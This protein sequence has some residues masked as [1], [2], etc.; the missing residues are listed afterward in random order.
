MR[1]IDKGW[2]LTDFRKY[3]TDKGKE[4]IIIMEVSQ[5]KKTL[6]FAAVV[7]AVI[8]AI[9][10]GYMQSS[11]GKLMRAKMSAS[12]GDYEKAL[13]HLSKEAATPKI[14]SYRHLY[15]ALNEADKLRSDNYFL[16][17][18]P[19]TEEAVDTYTEKMEELMDKLDN[20]ET[21]TGYVDAAFLSDPE[22]EKCTSLNEA[23]EKIN[24]WGDDLA[25]I[26]A[27]IE[28]YETLDR[29]EENIFRK[30]KWFVPNTVI[31]DVETWKSEI[32]SGNEIYKSLIGEDLD[33]YSNAVSM[34]D[35][36]IND[37]NNDMDKNSSYHYTKYSG[38]YFVDPYSDED[39]E[40]VYNMVKKI[41][42]AFY[43]EIVIYFDNV[44]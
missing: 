4:W 10:I 41:S 9:V 40:A 18:P 27:A 1:G 37:M 8:A 24:K 14:E 12:S 25:P 3:K 19:Y 38:D 7:V 16:S 42:A 15:S 2:V 23:V 35:S 32:N 36:V 21:L 13:N 44:L 6:V 31:N 29:L 34:C 20:I 28:A 39:S 26:G 5:K 43:K 33:E 30:G 11:S 17:D 22:N